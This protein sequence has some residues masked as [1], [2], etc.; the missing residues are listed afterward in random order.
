VTPL[1]VIQKRQG[2]SIKPA[3]RARVGALLPWLGRFGPDSAQ[4]CSSFSFFFFFQTL[5]IYKK[6]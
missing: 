2:L 3:L 6:L 1:Q 5:E 4:N